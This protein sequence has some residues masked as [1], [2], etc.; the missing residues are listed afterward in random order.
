MAPN[1]PSLSGHLV[2]W[3]GL[4]ATGYLAIV[5]FEKVQHAGANV[6]TWPAT[7]ALPSSWSARPRYVLSQHLSRKQWPCSRRW[8][9]GGVARAV[10]TTHIW[11]TVSWPSWAPLFTAFAISLAPCCYSCCPGREHGRAAGNWWPVQSLRVAFSF[12]A[13][14]G[15]RDGDYRVIWLFPAAGVIRRHHD[16]APGAGRSREGRI[17]RLWDRMS[18]SILTSDGRDARCS[19]GGDGGRRRRRLVVRHGPQHP[20]QSVRDSPDRNPTT[21]LPTSSVRPRRRIRG[22]LHRR[23]TGRPDGQDE[24]APQA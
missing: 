18:E 8:P 6:Q 11:Q 1:A 21:R 10:H 19:V 22:R 20:G 3:S 23:G 12:L 4:S 5:Y 9:H 13:A 16:Q 24:S 2:F 15:G 14:G 7:S 17:E